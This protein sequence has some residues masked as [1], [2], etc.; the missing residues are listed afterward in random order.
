LPCGTWPPATSC[1]PS[2]VL[3]WTRWNS[4]A[5]GFPPMVDPP[6]PVTQLPVHGRARN[7]L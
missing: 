4:A 7:R 3:S 5:C 1:A 2:C 6:D